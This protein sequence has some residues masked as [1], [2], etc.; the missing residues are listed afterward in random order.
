MTQPISENKLVLFEA[1]RVVR[2]YQF[3]NYPP[4][5]VLRWEG[6]KPVRI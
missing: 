4:Q 6:Y 1:L 5:F 2:F 3:F